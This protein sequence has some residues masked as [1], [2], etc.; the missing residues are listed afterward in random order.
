MDEKD[1]RIA[2]LEA[3]QLKTFV[4]ISELERQLALNSRNSGKPPSND[5]LRTPPHPRHLVRRERNLTIT[6]TKRNSSKQ[7]QISLSQKEFFQALII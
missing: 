1:K 3:L 5:G 6:F 2:E 4:R 7:Y